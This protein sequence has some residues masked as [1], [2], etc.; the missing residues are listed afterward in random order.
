MDGDKG[1]D[2]RQRV[3]AKEIANLLQLCSN[4][5]ETRS[6]LTEAEQ[7]DPELAGF[8][9]ETAPLREQGGSENLDDTMGRSQDRELLASGKPRPDPPRAP[10]AFSF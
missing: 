10:G 9:I 6:F 7:S 4:G 3:R 8:W 1:I 2:I 5:S